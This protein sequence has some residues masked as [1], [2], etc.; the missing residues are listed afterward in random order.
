M[1]KINIKATMLA[2]LKKRSSFWPF[3]KDKNIAAASSTRGTSPISKDMP[4]AGPGSD[5]P[6]PQGECKS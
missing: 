1:G 6:Y 5:T 4:S 2:T 3:L